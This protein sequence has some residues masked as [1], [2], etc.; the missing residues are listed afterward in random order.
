MAGALSTTEREP[1]RALL[2]IGLWPR[3]MEKGAILLALLLFLALASWQLMLPGLNYDEAL[4]VVPAMQLLL[5]QSTEPL[6]GSGLR[7]GGRTFPL[8]VMD[9]KGVVHTYWA[10]PF[11]WALGVNVFALRLSCLFLSLL[12]MASVYRFGRQFYGSR[13]AVVSLLLLAVNPCF[14]F[15]SRQG[16]LWTTAMLT[17]GMGALAALGRWKGGAQHWRLYLAAFVLGLGVSAKLPFVWFVVAL[18]ISAIL[19][20]ARGLWAALPIPGAERLGRR[21]KRAE[22]APTGG[23]RIVRLGVALLAL[24]LGLSPLLIYNLQTRGTVDVVLLNLR[25]SYYGVN[26][27]A[28]VPNLGLRWDHLRGLLDG[29]NFWYLG[30]IHRDLI[31]PLAFWISAAVISIW[32]L[33]RAIRRP[34]TLRRDDGSWRGTK[35]PQSPCALPPVFPLLMMTLI[36][37]QSGFTVSGLWPEH[38]L[39]LVPFPQLIIALGLD[40]LGSDLRRRR[41]LSWG[42]LLLLALLMASQLRV[43]VLYHRALG[44]SGGFGAHSDA[45]YKLADYLERKGRPVVAMDWGIKAPVQFLTQGRVN[46]QE[47]F[48]FQN[49]DRPSPDFAAGVAAYLEDRDT[50]YIFHAPPET[51]YQARR[52]AFERLVLDRGLIPDGKRI[53]YDRSARPLFVVMEVDEA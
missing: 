20:N 42:C 11:L 38:Y 29:S 47:R 52:E 2:F 27:L 50:Y 9:Y 14:L 39:L 10:F 8:M 36:V 15:W 5:G 41:S 7:V 49:L 3:W 51:V 21:R 33:G 12:T 17:C 25:T 24:L 23:G 48:G 22:L 31:F 1:Q 19:L 30:A 44:Q 6:R 45:N 26:N 34:W 4:D 18:A 37:V 16:V 13:V 35:R 53:I 40:M 43:D 28:Y 46:P 32:S